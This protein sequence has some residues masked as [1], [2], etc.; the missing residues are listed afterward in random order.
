MG[1]TRQACWRSR[2]CVHDMQI[3]VVHCAPWVV[4]DACPTVTAAYAYERIMPLDVRP[5]YRWGVAEPTVAHTRA[6]Q[7]IPRVAD[8]RHLGVH[9]VL[10]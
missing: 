10:D 9:S 3:I 7:R 6:G 5:S 2:P 4:P 1:T 8:A